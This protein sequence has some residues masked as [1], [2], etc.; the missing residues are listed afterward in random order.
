MISNPLPQL[1]Q[2]TG[3]APGV[4]EPGAPLVVVVDDQSA[5]RRILVQLIRGIASDIEVV[6]FADAAAAL[7]H[8][9][10]RTPD[11][12]IT[13]YLMPGL[14]GVGFIRRVRELPGGGDVPIIVV[15]VS[16]ERSVRYKALD[17]GATDF[18]HRPIDEHECRARCRN[19]LTLRRQQQ[20]LKLRAL[21]LAESERRFRIMADELPLIVWVEDTR[22]EVAFVNKPGCDFF[23][24][25]EAD[26]S[27]RRWQ[28][29]LHPDDREQY[30]SGYA[31]RFAA[32]EPHQ[33]Q[34]RMRRGDGEWRWVESYARPYFDALG[35]FAGVVGAS[36]DITERKM[37]EES[38]HLSHVELARRSEQLERL[39]SQLTRAEQRERKRL[40]KVIHD[41][42]QQLL[43]G[44]AF[45]VE[46]VDR[47]LG[48]FD[49]A[50]ALRE[51]LRS[52]NDLL[53]Q[54]I[55][56]A[57]S[58]VGNLSPPILHDAGLAE[59]LDWLA[60]QM[61]QRFGLKVALDVDG[62]VPQPP[63][64]LR[65]AA[66]EAAREAL[67]NVVKHADVDHAR[68]IL[69]S[70]VD[71]RVQL[72]IED[73]GL[74]FDT[75]A[76]CSE[77]ATD[78]GFG[79]LSTRERL[80]LLGGELRCDSAPGAGTRVVVTVPTD[81]A[82]AATAAGADQARPPD[83]GSEPAA[84]GGSE[85]EPG[86]GILLVDDHAMLRGA[87]ATMLAAE[88]DMRIVG[89]AADGVEAIAAVERLMPEV[90]LMDISMPR[91]DGLEATRRIT[92]RWPGVRVIGLSMHHRD[93]RAEA[94]QAA[95][96]VAYLC[97]SGDVA[98]LLDTIRRVIA[99]GV[100]QVPA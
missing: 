69:G 25:S 96:A 28:A 34:C 99:G 61:Q 9:R 66:F 86:I 22:G 27:G 55:G 29:L 73:Q 82:G 91:M 46:R 14:D 2:S 67:F 10:T 62:D 31:P 83:A 13:D 50:E 77:N 23:G 76:H 88:A 4:T 70:L 85:D 90:V 8:I 47:R 17:A 93:D 30:L 36:L 54:A 19:L 24:L 18:L 78:G 33:D 7:N 60:R 52:A 92:A 5:G 45:S 43:V 41:D 63:D 75:V 53:K 100:G 94:M 98:L 89:E 44:A 6:A 49:G 87:L 48:R 1:N 59:A 51:T 81:T 40:A 80:H 16:D 20:I 57:R 74:G 38:L 65:S 72:V 26:L 32:R 79:L 12:V 11:L 58:L 37:A 56:V 39:T 15:T 95:G 97:K 21:S 71:G 84:A 68:L 64:D 35:E 3:A 42:L